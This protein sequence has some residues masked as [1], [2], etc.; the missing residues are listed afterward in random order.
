M[1]IESQTDHSFLLTGE[2]MGDSNPIKP[3]NLKK[4]TYNTIQSKRFIGTNKTVTICGKVVSTHLS[5]NGH[6]FLNLDQSFPEQIFSIT[7]WK[8]NTS[9]FSYLPHL[10]LKNKKICVKGKVNENKGIPTM[11]IDNEK[12]IYIQEEEN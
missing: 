12:S 4:G 11:T 2:K 6:V 3:E 5:K 8:S 9:N 7:I 10:E 1:L